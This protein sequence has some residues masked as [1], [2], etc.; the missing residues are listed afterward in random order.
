GI[1]DQTLLVVEPGVYSVDLTNS[2]GC[3]STDITEGIELCK[4][5]IVAPT[6]FRPGSTID[7][8]REFG[9]LTFFIDDSGFEVF[10]FNRWGEMVYQSND[11]LFRWN[12]G[13]NNNFS[14]LLP[15]GTYTYVVKYRSIYEEEIQERR[16]GV[17][18]MRYPRSIFS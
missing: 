10:I 12:G 4:P 16:G 1:T 17:V 13:Y 9:V 5:R 2:F 15:A 8:N 6:A 11:R 3:V 7:E 18:S 14:Q